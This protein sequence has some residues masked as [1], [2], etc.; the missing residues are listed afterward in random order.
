VDAL[1]LLGTDFRD[2]RA[3]IEEMRD[4]TWRM[5]DAGFERSEADPGDIW[6]AMIAEALRE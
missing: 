4:P 5:M 6:R 3:A 2:A 1:P